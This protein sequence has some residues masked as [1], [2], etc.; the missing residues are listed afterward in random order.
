MRLNEETKRE[1][2]ETLDKRKELLHYKQEIVRDLEENSQALG[3]IAIDHKLYDCLSINY[4]RLE[5]Y[6]H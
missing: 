5:R 4:A 3:A 6:L 1:L 2:Q